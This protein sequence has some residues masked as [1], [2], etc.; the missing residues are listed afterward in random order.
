LLLPQK[1]DA[2]SSYGEGYY[3]GQAYYY[4]QAY[5]YTQAYY[6]AQGYYTIITTGVTAP[7]SI[8]VIGT[9]S[10]GSG[11]FMIDHPLDPKNKILFHSFVE[12]P[13]VKNLYTGEVVLDKKGEAVIYLPSYF[14]ALNRDFRYQATGVEKAMP[15][16][17]LKKGVHRRFFIGAPVFILSGGEPGGKVSWQV[18]GVR[19][20]P[21]IEKFPIINE[22]VKTKNTEI[23]EGTCLYEPLCR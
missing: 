1:T 11:S 22:V 5:Y 20:D 3:Y 16:L 21:L 9:L 13:E 4:A 10:K 8:S 18:S 12:S 23:K 17:H 7:G 19:K 6:Y 14:L 2:S 15:N